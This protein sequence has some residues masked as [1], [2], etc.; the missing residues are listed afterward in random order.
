MKT[1]VLETFGRKTWHWLVGKQRM[2]ARITIQF[3]D[4]GI[5]KVVR[6]KGGG[7]VRVRVITSF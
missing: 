4:F 5:G 7:W 3:V 2:A 6:Q 1:F